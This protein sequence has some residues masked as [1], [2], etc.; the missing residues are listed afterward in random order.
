MDNKE[1]A[2]KILEEVLG[3]ENNKKKGKKNALIN[4]N[5][6]KGLLEVARNILY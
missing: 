6:K 3:K 1:K 5:Q 2:L 4:R